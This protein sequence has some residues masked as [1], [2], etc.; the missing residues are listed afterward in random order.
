M[1]RGHDITYITLNENAELRGVSY[2][3]FQCSDIIR[4]PE[5]TGVYAVPSSTEKPTHGPTVK[6]RLGLFSRCITLIY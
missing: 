4:A 3:Q 5:P 1:P 2:A 6:F